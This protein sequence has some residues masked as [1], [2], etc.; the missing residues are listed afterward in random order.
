[1]GQ[2]GSWDAREDMGASNWSET[3]WIAR[4]TR[5][6]R[7]PK[8]DEVDLGLP[9]KSG[10]VRGLGEL[11]GLLAELAKALARLEGGWSGLA[12]MAEMSSPELRR[13]DWPVKVSA[14]RSEA[15]PGRLYRRGRARPRARARDGLDRT[16]GRA[17]ARVGR[18][19]ACRPGS[20]TCAR[21]FCPSSGACG[22][23]SEPAL[24]LV[25]AQNLFSSLQAT[26][27]VWGS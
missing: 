7:R 26:D 23:S 20:N 14:G 19:L 22:R 2:R 16:P 12:A 8:S 25:S 21:A 15:R 6:G 18:A 11:H 4:S 13:G 10:R 24:A 3:H 5:G 17:R 1:M 27:L 9:V